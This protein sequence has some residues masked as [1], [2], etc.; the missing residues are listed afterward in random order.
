VPI[1]VAASATR[2]TDGSEENENQKCRGTFA[3][4][5]ESNYLRCNRRKVGAL[6]QTNI[7]IARRC[8]ACL[9]AFAAVAILAAP[10]ARAQ[11]HA[12]PHVGVGLV[13]DAAAVQPGKTLWVGLQFQLPD[14]WHIYW[15]NPG[16]SGE[17]PKIQWNLPQGFHAGDFLWPYPSRI[18]APSIVDYGY[19][20]SVLLLAPIAVPADLRQRGS[21]TL[22]GDVRYL[23]CREMCVPGKAS[24][25]LVLPVAASAGGSAAASARASAHALFEQT[26]ERL[27][28]PAPAAWQ[29]RVRS[30]SDEFILSL[31]AGKDAPQAEF[32]PLDADV[33]ENAAP[34]AVQS[35]AGGIAIHL[36]K[37]DQLLK[38][39]ARLRGVLVLPGRGAYRVDAA[40]TP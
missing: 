32:F 21:V 14:G 9:A 24:V 26:R 34:Q 3:L 23:V 8:A 2:I 27:P 15:T 31:R 30:T 4:L 22:G 28:Q 13:S 36:R 11:T 37:S 16:D 5:R 19:A 33:I 18:E 38:P 29:V 6:T 12:P 25:Q 39:I 20:S 35:T 17:P 7:S 1:C 40:V 10:A